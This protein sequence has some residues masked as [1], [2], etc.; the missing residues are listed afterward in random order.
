[1]GSIMQ[2]GAGVT[3]YSPDG[4]WEL[5]R[6][7]YAAH[8]SISQPSS[9]T[10][11]QYAKRDAPRGTQWDIGYNASVSYR[12][13]PYMRLHASASIRATGEVTPFMDI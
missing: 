8:Y 3:Y 6:G 10:G 13:N 7:V 5:S 2:A 11:A 12:I 9:I 4:H 1:M